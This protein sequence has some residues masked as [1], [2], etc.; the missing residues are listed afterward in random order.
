MA[1]F[2]AVAPL[3]DYLGLSMRAAVVVAGDTTSHAKPHPAPLLYA[4]TQMRVAPCDCIYVGDDLR[5][6]EAGHAAGMRTIA[7]A[8]GYCAD[9]DPHDWNADA[10]IDEPLELLHVLN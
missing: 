8:W 2:K 4:A 5:D 1:T 7:A 3:V 9:S 10:V 6:I